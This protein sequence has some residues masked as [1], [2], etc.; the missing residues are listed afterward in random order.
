MCRELH[1]ATELLTYVEFFKTRILLLFWTALLNRK[2]KYSVVLCND[3]QYVQCS[4]KTML[5]NG[6]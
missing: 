6:I 5:Q 4:D 1:N 2:I 3:S